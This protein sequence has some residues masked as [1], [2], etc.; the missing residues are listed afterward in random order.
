MGR[1]RIVALLCAL[2]LNVLCGSLVLSSAMNIK[3]YASELTDQIDEGELSDE[4]YILS[5]ND[6]N[7]DISYVEE[8]HDNSTSDIGTEITPIDM[9]K[10]FS[11]GVIIGLVT[12]ILI[13]GWI[14]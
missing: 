9:I 1:G 6:T 8:D 4:L 11:F 10:L 5:E 7:N 13:L 12:G 14:R 2:F 3:A